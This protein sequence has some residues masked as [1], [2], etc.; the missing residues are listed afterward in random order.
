MMQYEIFFDVLIK[1][2]VAYSVIA[3]IATLFISIKLKRKGETLS[4]F[5]ILNAF[6]FGAGLAGLIANYAAGVPISLSII[7]LLL[8]TTL[9]GFIAY[10]N[11]FR[12]IFIESK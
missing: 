10:K 7:T 11:F 1:A 4:F 8:V 9:S 2:C 12:H 3:V 5:V 6:A